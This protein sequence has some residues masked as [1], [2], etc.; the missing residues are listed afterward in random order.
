MESFPLCEWV[1]VSAAES[2]ASI[3]Q[4]A[5]AYLELPLHEDVYFYTE[6]RD[7]TNGPSLSFETGCSRD[8]AAFVAMVAPFAMAM[9][10]RT[11]AASADSVAVPLARFLRWRLVKGAGAGVW[12]ASFR[13]W[14][15]ALAYG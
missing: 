10:V 5:S 13:I 15:A 8:E 4:P 14:V 6:V 11:D 12:G 3:P 7:L 9:G 1:N 2:V